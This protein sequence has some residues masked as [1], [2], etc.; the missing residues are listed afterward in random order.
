MDFI[1][2]R[3]KYTNI[4]STVAPAFKSFAFASFF[5]ATTAL[6]M[7]KYPI[8]YLK[9]DEYDERSPFFRFF[10]FWFSVS[11]VKFRYYAGW[12]LSQISIDASGFSYNGKD[13]DGKDKWDAI[14]CFDPMLELSGNLRTKI[15]VKIHEFRNY[16]IAYLTLDVEYLYT[17]MVQE[18]CL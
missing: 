7:P 8:S 2:K 9:T 11:F 3:G 18:I 5:M 6:I 1:H 16:Y 14:R 17:I 13:Q 12:M 10:Y 4:P 15:E